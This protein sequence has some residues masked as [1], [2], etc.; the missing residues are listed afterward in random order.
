MELG[1]RLKAARQEAGLS[2]RQLCGERLTRNMLSQIEN[3]S[4][5]PSMETLKYLAQQLGKSVSYFLEEQAVTSPN[6]AVMEQARRC[7]A[8]GDAA[9]TVTALEDYREPDG[10]FDQ[11]RLLLRE[12]ALLAL[13][14]QAIGEG[15]TIYAAELLQK[16]EE[17]LGLYH[18]P[19]LAQRRLVLRAQAQPHGAAEI[20]RGLQVD[21]VLLLKAKAALAGSEAARCLELLSAAED[22]ESPEW[23]WLRG[24]AYLALQEY[25]LALRCY[26][27]AEPAY[28]AEALPRLER[29][30]RELGDYKGAYEYA[31][32]QLEMRG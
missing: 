28:P 1:Q 29:C 32:K 5:R 30:C 3:G 26:R 21:E 22:K 15:K 4:A 11:E 19:E 16:V 9:G 13:A 10:V 27:Q 24:E 8:A 31:C 7:W 12:L 14:E 18:T 2:Q 17:A 25:A 23:N 20:A 6:L